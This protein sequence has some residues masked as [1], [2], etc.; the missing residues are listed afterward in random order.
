MYIYKY[1]ENIKSGK[2]I[3]FDSFCKQ[4]RLKEYDDQTIL[5]IFSTQKISRLSY[6]VS[7]IDDKLF[8][9]LL[10]DFPKYSIINRVSAARAGDSHKHPVSQAMIILWPSQ[11]SH[12]VVVLNDVNGIKSPVAL[13]KRLLI[14]ENQENFVQKNESLAFLKHQFSDFNDEGLDIAWGSGNA[15]SNRL[16]KAFFNHYPHIDC[17]LDLD[18]GGLTTFANICELTSHPRISFLLPSCA[19]EQLKSSKMDL[20]NGH[21]PTLRKFRENYPLLKPAIELMIHHKKMLEQETYL[22]D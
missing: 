9:Q 21:L 12:P 7:I 6:Q 19:D 17:L 1:L 18:I 14:I 5:R 11:Q 2:P 15:I 10:A 16:N 13:G 3:N 4:L 22:L 8:A 20:Q